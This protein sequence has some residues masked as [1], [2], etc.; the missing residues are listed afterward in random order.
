MA[1]DI[2]LALRRIDLQKTGQEFFLDFQWVAT[3]PNWRWNWMQ[4]PSRQ[5]QIMSVCCSMG[6]RRCLFFRRMFISEVHHMQQCCPYIPPSFSHDQLFKETNYPSH[7]MLPMWKAR[8]MDP[9]P[10]QESL[11]GQ[12]QLA[13]EL[14]SL[15]CQKTQRKNIHRILPSW[16]MG[17]WV[18]QES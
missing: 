16:D 9:K 14:A 15:V 4:T 2:L 1:N 6:K 13:E 11:D 5:C 10:C 3:G 17:R 8:N 12:E 7:V 18:D